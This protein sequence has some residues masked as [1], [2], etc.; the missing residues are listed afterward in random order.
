M[1]A[2]DSGGIAGATGPA[3]T[4]GAGRGRRGRPWADARFFL[5][6]V[7][8]A[9]SVVGVWLVVAAARQ[10][11]PVY[12][13]ARTIVAGQRVTAAD[14]RVADAALGAAAPT[15]LDPHTG[16]EPDA[17]ATR[18]I[19]TGELVPLGAVGG[20]G[21]VH[22]TTV[23]VPSAQDVPESIRAGA[24]VEVWAAPQTERGRYDKPRIVVSDATVAAV[25]HDEAMVGA[26]TAQLELV[27]P[28]SD[29]AELLDALANGAA[30][31]VVPA[32]SAG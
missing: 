25:A 21:D 14:L 13:A 1:T 2:L 18:T 6:I 20:A 4:A 11:A 10:T 30:V 22:T 27:I 15:Y 29:V 9:A 8:I 28:R 24:A 3:A 16:L 23:V 31:S 26:S 12:V 7:L 19:E 32:G 17:V 5:G